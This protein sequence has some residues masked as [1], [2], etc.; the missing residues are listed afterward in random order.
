MIFFLEITNIWQKSQDC[1]FVNFFLEI[2]KFHSLLGIFLWI[3]GGFEFTASM[4]CL[5]LL[6]KRC[7]VKD[8]L[9]KHFWVS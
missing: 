9:Q 4:Y 5:K 2:F 8:N 6:L 1:R 7:F 3:F